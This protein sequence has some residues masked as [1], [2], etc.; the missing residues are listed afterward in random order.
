MGEKKTA[1]PK[2]IFWL[3]A[4]DGGWK[5]WFKVRRNTSR[6]DAILSTWYA[7]CNGPCVW[8]LC[9]CVG[10]YVW[11]LYHNVHNILCG[12]YFVMPWYHLVVSYRYESGLIGLMKII[13]T[14][15]TFCS[16]GGFNYFPSL[17]AKWNCPLLSKKKIASELCKTNC[18]I[19][20]FI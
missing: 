13:V 6:H 2:I 11:E 5:L 19:I 20:I 14:C 12:Q 7:N 16:G 18:T 3:R 9:D 15:L 8:R 17:Y 4:W 10:P 1:R